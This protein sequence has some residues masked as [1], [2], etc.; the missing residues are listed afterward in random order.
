MTSQLQEGLVTWAQ[1]RSVLS[2]ALIRGHTLTFANNIL[3]ADCQAV[4][5]GRNPSKLN[6]KSGW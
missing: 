5:T 6:E 4:W 2:N 1:E 3:Q